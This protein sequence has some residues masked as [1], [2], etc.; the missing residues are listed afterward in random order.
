MPSDCDDDCVDYSLIFKFQLQ[1]KIGKVFLD[2]RLASPYSY[3]VI[4]FEKH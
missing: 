4:W 1:N 3:I 2:F